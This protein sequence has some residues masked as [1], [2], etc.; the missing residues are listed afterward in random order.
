MLME[1]KLRK[2]GVDAL[3]LL[4]LQVFIQWDKADGKLRGKG[5]PQQQ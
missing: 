2:L 5:A 3:F 1:K 4:W